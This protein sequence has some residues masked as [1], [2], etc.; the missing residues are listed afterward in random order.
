[1][2]DF[3]DTDLT[4]CLLAICLTKDMTSY[5]A[6]ESRPLVG[7]SM[8]RILGL[9]INWDATLTRRFWPPLIPL[10]IGVPMSVFAWLVRPKAVSRAWILAT[11]SVLA[12]ELRN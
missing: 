12:I 11:R 2:G 3:R 10:R 8:K 9:V 5:A 4:L 6:A 1:L 7:S